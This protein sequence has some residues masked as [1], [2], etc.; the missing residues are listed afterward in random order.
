M[1]I[2]I[3]MYKIPLYYVLCILIPLTIVVIINNYFNIWIDLKRPRL[4][5]SEES[6]AVKQNLNA[7][8]SIFGTIG[9]CAVFGVLA[10]VFYYYNVTINVVLLSILISLICGIILGLVI[11]YFYKNSDKLVKSID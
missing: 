4:K 1:I 10:F 2:P 9:L 3:V 7:M 5:W 8:I 11:Y 6:E